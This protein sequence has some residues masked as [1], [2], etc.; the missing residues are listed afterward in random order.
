MNTYGSKELTNLVVEHGERRLFALRKFMKLIMH[1]EAT[2]TSVWISSIFLLL[3]YG[4][5]RQVLVNFR[6]RAI[7]WKSGHVA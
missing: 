1:A 6:R 2:P 5:N 4:K 3:A 7:P